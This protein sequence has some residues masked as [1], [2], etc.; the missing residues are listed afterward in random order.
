MA[1]VHGVHLNKYVA[2]LAVCLP[3]LG[4]R[5]IRASRLRE[6]AERGSVLSLLGAGSSSSGSVLLPS[7]RGLYGP[8]PTRSSLSRIHAP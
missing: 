5:P 8:Q 7:E 6:E 1:A 4:N 2:G 3:L